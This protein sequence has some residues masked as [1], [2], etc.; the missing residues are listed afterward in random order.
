M[1]IVVKESRVERSQRFRATFFVSRNYFETHQ[2]TKH[3]HIH[4]TCT[5]HGNDG[6]LPHNAT[7]RMDP[8][9]K[10][11]DK[12]SRIPLCIYTLIHFLSLRLY[13][14]TARSCMACTNSRPLSCHS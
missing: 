11:T 14:A 3:K 6:L 4:R 8:K 2:Y 5:D 1:T 9:R 13:L 10:Y 7:V 12:Y